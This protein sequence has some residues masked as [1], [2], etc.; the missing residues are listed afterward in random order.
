MRALMRHSISWQPF[1]LK[2]MKSEDI[3]STGK[4]E[5]QAVLT[6][7]DPQNLLLETSSAG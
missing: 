7:T 5:V 1:V 6:S 4:V 2:S 3:E